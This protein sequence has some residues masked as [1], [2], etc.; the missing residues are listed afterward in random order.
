MNADL[1]GGKKYRGYI[2]GGGGAKRTRIKGNFSRGGDIC[3]ENIYLHAI[4]MC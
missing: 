4:Y 2:V 1:S 3:T